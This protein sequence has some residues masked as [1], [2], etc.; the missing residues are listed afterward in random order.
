[1]TT[2]NKI[3]AK[4]E[5][6]SNVVNKAKEST[7]TYL[8]GKKKKVEK[9]AGGYKKKIKKNPIKSAVIAILSGALVVGLIKSIFTKK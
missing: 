9:I 2:K 6:N 3:R 5:N 7:K 4:K 8:K 1:M